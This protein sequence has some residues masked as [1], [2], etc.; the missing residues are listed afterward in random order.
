MAIT[1]RLSVRA[2][3]VLWG[4][5]EL[6]HAELHR[7]F[8]G[9]ININEA[10][11]VAAGEP[12]P[13]SLVALRRWP[14]LTPLAAALMGGALEDELW[15]VAD[16][17]CDWPS[18]GVGERADWLRGVLRSVRLGV[19]GS[20]MECSQMARAELLAAQRAR[21]S[22][23]AARV[24]ELTDA[25]VRAAAL[26]VLAGHMGLFGALRVSCWERPEAGRA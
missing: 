10:M 13:G 12:W 7:P 9:R 17:L 4:G 21:G 18:W 8:G 23:G 25:A 19:L 16:A 24:A 3:V 15:P 20:G 1:G 11:A 22:F 6:D 5:G 2:A 26:D 14:D